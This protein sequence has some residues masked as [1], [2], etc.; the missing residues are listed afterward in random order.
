MTPSPT[1][2]LAPRPLPLT[3]AALPGTGGTA[4]V[5][6]EDF[7]VEEVPAYLPSGA[8]EH[9]YL[10]IEK[11][12]LST[13][14]AVKTI[15]RALGVSD[16]DVGYAGQKDRK[17]ITRQWISVHTKSAAP[18]S[19]D[20]NLQILEASR[21][22]NKLRLGHTKGNRFTLTVRGTAPDAA[23]R[24]Q[25]TLAHLAA[26][27]L[28]NFYGVQRF[29]RK[30]DNAAL[31][32]ALLWLGEHTELAFAKKDRFLKRLALSALQ[33]ELFNRVLTARLN[34]GL[35]DEVF[36]GDVLRKR[37][38]G[39]VFLCTDAVTDRERL[40]SREIDVTGPMPGN[41]ERPAATGVP[42]EREDRVLAEAGVPREAFA[43]A[44]DEAEGARRPFRIPLDGATAKAVGD[45][46]LELSF[47]LPSGSYA[48]RVLAEVMKSDLSL[49]GED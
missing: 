41:R 23:A 9:L 2:D 36:V 42:R 44:G 17:A 8:G 21:H 22:G 38:S 12:G 28:A 37:E 15:A 35:F 25:A 5:S 32:A 33:S 27:G 26:H 48:T 24:A 19:D 4:K 30:G 34:D 3:T 40:H 43:K 7:L 46:A 39:G 49:P 10:W 11:R 47:E 45:D 20:P 14:E 6:P 13:S 16:R 1:I 29:G 18:T 31:G